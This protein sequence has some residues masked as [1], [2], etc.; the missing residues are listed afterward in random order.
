MARFAVI[1]LGRFGGQLAR[2]LARAGAE[3]I[4][5]DKDRKLIEDIADEVT[6]AVRLDS[7]DEEALHAHAIEKVD[8]AIVGIGQDFEANILTTV[9]LK[10]LGVKHI[11]VRAERQTHGEIL[12]RIGADEV[13]FPE[14]ESAFRWS[15]KLL[16]PRISEK[17]EFA[18]GFSLAQYNAPASF[19]NKTLQD[20]NLRKKY[21]V[22]LIGLRKAEDIAEDI[23]KTSGPVINVPLPETIIHEG[24]LLW[25]VGSDADLAQLP[26]K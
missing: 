21:H 5:I 10:S 20:L 2:M 15:Y 24:D 7:T 1:G 23:K 3:V 6:L 14:E 9:T 17:L 16:A 12:R 25:L 19:H 8:V 26:G 4:A 22:N 13:I 11:C 18:P